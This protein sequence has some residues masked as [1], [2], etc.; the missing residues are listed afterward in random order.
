MEPR[1]IWVNLLV[2][3]GVA[4]AVSS[5]LV[6]SK[7]FK[8]LLFRE[9]REFRQKVY[10]VLWMALPIM[11]GVWIRFSAQ[12]FLAG[13]LS[14]ETTLSG[15]DGANPNGGLIFRTGAIYGTTS[16]GGNT[17]ECVYTGFVGCG[18]AFVLRQ[19]ETWTEKIIHRFVDSPKDGALPAAGLAV[20]SKGVLYGTTVGGGN[21][22][23]GVVFNLRS[24]GNNHWA[25]T[26]LYNFQGGADGWGPVG[27]LLINSTGGIYGTANAAGTYSAGTLFELMPGLH[28][29]S[30]RF[31]LL[32]SFTGPPDA[33][34][35]AARL[36]FGGSGYLYGTSQGGGTGQACQGGC[37]AIFEAAP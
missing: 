25:E 12:S 35:P 13:D 2:K 10:L 17:A 24:T 37:G 7:E 19:G 11:I 26:I 4:A 16:R 36:V 29:P 9:Q 22:E 20:D 5:S 15:S 6:R 3:L 23:A 18:T 8:S 1:L 32:Y 34:F 27:G 28:R 33:E 30:W 14:F 31:D 21:E